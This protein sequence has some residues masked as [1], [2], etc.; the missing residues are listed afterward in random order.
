MRSSLDNYISKARGLEDSGQA[1]EAMVLA[2]ELVGKYPDEMRAWALR[3]Y[4]HT[5]ARD[6]AKANSDLDSAIGI[7]EADPYLYFRRGLNHLALG[8][9]ERAAEDFTRGLRLRDPAY[10][11]AFRFA[12]AEALIGLGRKREAMEDLATLPEE[13]KM[14]TNRLRTKAELVSECA[15]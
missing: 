13:H 10:E 7:N 3:A 9:W 1:K 4:L 11:K 15:G 2:N 12:R 5:L 8:G 14:W 6:Y